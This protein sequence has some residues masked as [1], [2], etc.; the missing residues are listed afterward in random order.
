[1]PCLPSYLSRSN[2]RCKMILI[3]QFKSPIFVKTNTMFV[4]FPWSPVPNCHLP[5]HILNSGQESSVFFL[6]SFPL[7]TAQSRAVEDDLGSPN[8]FR[9]SDTLYSSAFAHTLHS[10]SF[11]KATRQSFL[12]QTFEWFYLDGVNSCFHSIGSMHLWFSSEMP[13]LLCIYIFRWHRFLADFGFHCNLIQTC[14]NELS[15]KLF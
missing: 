9:I 1:M 6:F 4:F 7:K 5:T 3:L 10:L 15:S 11:R 12:K 2:M 8:W 14:M 13:R